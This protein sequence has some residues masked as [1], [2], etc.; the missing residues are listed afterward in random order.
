MR[1]HL[2][3][4]LLFLLGCADSRQTSSPSPSSEIIGQPRSR[5]ILSLTD[6]HFDPFY[7]PTLFPALVQ[8]P[9]SEW[10]RIFDGSRVAGYGLY[11]KDSNYNLFVSALRHAALAAP[12]ADFILLAGDWL[13]HGF[14][15]S[16]YQY[17][18]NRDPRGLHEF[19]DKTIVL[20][21]PTHSRTV[22]K[23]PDLPGLGQ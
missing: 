12:G 5:V 15:D 8:S 6:F 11:G 21:N 16:Y 10:T 7:D 20:F 13:A 17:A 3:I 23:H 1:Y 9:P 19:I 2:F 22:S 4:L 14:S 18:G